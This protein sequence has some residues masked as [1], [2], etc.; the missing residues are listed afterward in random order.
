MRENWGATAG[1][2]KMVFESTGSSRAVTWGM[3]ALSAITL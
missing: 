2:G 3:R 1:M